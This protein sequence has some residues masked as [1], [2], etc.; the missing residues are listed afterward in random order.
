MMGG[1]VNVLTGTIAGIIIGFVLTVQVSNWA[2]DAR[3]ERGHFEH[4]GSI[5]LVTPAKAVP[6]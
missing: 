2:D 3:I 4:R 1:V 6:R 5:Y